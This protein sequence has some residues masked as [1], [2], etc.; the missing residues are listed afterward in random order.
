[1]VIVAAT[2]LV[3]T[4]LLLALWQGITPR[5]IGRTLKD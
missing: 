1:M 2:S 4:G 5:S 3:V